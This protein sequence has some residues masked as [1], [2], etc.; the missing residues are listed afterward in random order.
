MSGTEDAELFHTDDLGLIVPADK[1]VF[2]HCT[3]QAIRHMRHHHLVL[4]GDAGQAGHT[5]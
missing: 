4:D 5:Q 3:G 1:M 2:G